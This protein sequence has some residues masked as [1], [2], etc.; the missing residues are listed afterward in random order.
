MG[1]PSPS[2]RPPRASY[3]PPPSHYEE[4]VQRPTGAV[5]LSVLGGLP[6]A[7]EGIATA[8][9]GSV[10]E[11][12]TYALLGEGLVVSGL[13]TAVVGILLMFVAYML[14]LQP[15]HHRADG[16]V[17]VVLAFAST[18]FS[19]GGF[20]IGF[21]LA[22]SGGSWAYSWKPKGRVGVEAIQHARN[23]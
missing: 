13:V 15:D 23:G 12:Y 4:S 2:Y 20:Y 8:A 9:Y 11:Q 19:A 14:F 7:A 21:L 1:Q 5:A 10:L 16:L 17:I 18:L 22:F 3:I 6:I